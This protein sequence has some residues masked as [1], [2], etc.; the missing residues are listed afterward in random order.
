MKK[1][2]KEFLIRGIIHKPVLRKQRKSSGISHMCWHFPRASRSMGIQLMTSLSC[3]TSSI[4]S[5]LSHLCLYQ[6]FFPTYYNNN[7]V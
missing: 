3:M 2:H 6:D 7:R 5:S 1:Q 4:T